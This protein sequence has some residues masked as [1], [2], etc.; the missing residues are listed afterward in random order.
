MMSLS[1]AGPKR[2]QHD[3]CG[4]PEYLSD[5][6]PGFNLEIQYEQ[7]DDWFDPKRACGDGGGRPMESAGCA[8]VPGREGEAT[9]G[10][11]DR[12]LSARGRHVRHCCEQNEAA[13]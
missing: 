2:R 6:A 8:R 5:A 7:T 13:A 12:G 10:P 4:G 3:F 1:D 11:G 9:D